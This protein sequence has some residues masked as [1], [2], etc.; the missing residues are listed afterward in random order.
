MNLIEKRDSDI[1]KLLEAIKEYGRWELEFRDMEIGFR[2]NLYRNTVYDT[3][4][5][6][7]QGVEKTTQ[8]IQGTT[9]V[10]PDGK[11]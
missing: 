4:E 5:D 7:P 1:Q 9:Q 8:D 3:L 11:G 2:I 10:R 6:I